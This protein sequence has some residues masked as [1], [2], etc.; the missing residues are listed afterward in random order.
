MIDVSPFNEKLGIEVRDEADG[1]V[2]LAVDAN[3]SFHNEVGAVHGGV[4]LFLLDGAMGR[5]ACR[6][7]AEG[8]SCATVQISIQFIAPLEGRIEARGQVTKRGRRIA[9]LEGTCKDRN[10]KLIARAQGTWAILQRS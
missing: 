10:G 7:L 8:E 5:A 6:T 1:S 4:A 2:V 3:A 9:F